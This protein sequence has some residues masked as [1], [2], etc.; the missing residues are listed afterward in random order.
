MPVRDY[1]RPVGKKPIYSSIDESADF[2]VVHHGGIPRGFIPNF[3][4]TNKNSYNT[5]EQS[6]P[7]IR[8]YADCTAGHH[9]TQREAAKLKL[10]KSRKEFSI[11]NNLLTDVWAEITTERKTAI[12]NAHQTLLMAIQDPHYTNPQKYA[13]QSA[14]L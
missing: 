13:L 7:T 14:H 12:E 2:S 6:T 3:D 10:E 1:L 9:P 5:L 8:D 4:R 11:M